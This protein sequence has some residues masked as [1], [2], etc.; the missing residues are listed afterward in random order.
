M[1]KLKTKKVSKTEIQIKTESEEKGQVIIHCRS[2]DFVRLWQHHTFLIP[3][4]Y[5]TICKLV[6]SEGIS[7]YPTWIKGP[8]SF[9]LIFEGLPKGC[10]RFDLIEQIPEPGGF[11]YLG[12]FRNKTDV[13]KITF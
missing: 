10:E 5:N 7:L 11:R 13:Y 8:V 12:I 1:E 6:H 2:S 9:T 3:H 4:G